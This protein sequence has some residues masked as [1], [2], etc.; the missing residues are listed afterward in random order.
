MAGFWDTACCCT[1]NGCST[2][3]TGYCFQFS[4]SGVTNSPPIFPSTLPPC[5]CCPDFNGTW[6]LVPQGPID[7]EADVCWWATCAPPG[8]DLASGLYPTPVG[9][10]GPG[11]RFQMNPRDTDKDKLLGFEISGGNAVYRSSGPLLNLTAPTIFTLYST[12]GNACQGWP[13]TISVTAVPPT[14]IGSQTRTAQSFSTAGQEPDEQPQ[15]ANGPGFWPWEP[16]QAM[17]NG[18]ITPN[19]YIHN[20]SKGQTTDWLIC[21]SFGFNIPG[22]SWITG[23]SISFK[24]WSDQA[25]VAFDDWVTVGLA[26]TIGNLGGPTSANEAQ[27]GAWPQFVAGATADVA[28]YGGQ[29]D[30]WQNG[31]TMQDFINSPDWCIAIG[32]NLLAMTAGSAWIDPTTVQM[33][34]Y[35][36][37]PCSFNC[38]ACPPLADTGNPPS[39]YQVTFPAVCGDGASPGNTY[40]NC[41]CSYVSDATFELPYVAVESEATYICQYTLTVD[42]WTF[43][44]TITNI[45]PDIRQYAFRAGT[46]GACD[47]GVGVTSGGFFSG[48]GFVEGA[49]EAIKPCEAINITLDEDVFDCYCDLV[50]TIGPGPPPPFPTLSFTPIQ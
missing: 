23:I 6:L 10:N 44:L 16:S 24:R 14:A 32:A 42:N 15:V 4:I 33:T 41:N 39:A 47:N 29:F 25:A 49:N 48:V 5:C 50:I 13:S 20:S 11:Y 28:S 26:S 30:D 8:C 27:S 9:Q 7:P 17:L 40:P 37:I 45:G 35:Y 19:P 3:F 34:V 12:T 31:G 21:G 43:S 1:A 2:Q 36:V 38:C 22:T 46:G 18:L